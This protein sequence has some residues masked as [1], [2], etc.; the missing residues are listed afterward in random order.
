MA[1]LAGIVGL[2]LLLAAVGE[3]RAQEPQIAELAQQTAP[4]AFDR[5]APPDTVPDIEGFN[6]RIYREG[7]VY[8]AGQPTVEALEAVAERGVTAVINLR[9]PGEMDDREAVPFDEQKKI[10]TFNDALC[11]GCGTCAAACPSGAIRA[12]HFTSE[13]IL[14][15]VM[16]VLSI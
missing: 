13:Q 6:R 1:A 8:I 5:S 11:K 16:Q 10:A 2:T 9:T 15:Q 12:K 7:R 3:S 4:L 14:S